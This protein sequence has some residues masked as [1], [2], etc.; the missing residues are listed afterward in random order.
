MS[1]IKIVYK[2]QASATFEIA[3]KNAEKFLMALENVEAQSFVLQNVKI[4][5]KNIES[6]WLHVFPVDE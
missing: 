3:E 2:D 4:D 6:V 5:P 1:K